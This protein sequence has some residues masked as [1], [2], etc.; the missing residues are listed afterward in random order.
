M[1]L[2]PE[3]KNYRAVSYRKDLYSDFTKSCTQKSPVKIIKS[4]MVPNFIDSNVT[5]IQVNE[6]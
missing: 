2:Q 3:S 1:I 6:H 5:D 4:K